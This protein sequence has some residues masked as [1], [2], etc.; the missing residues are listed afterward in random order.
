MNFTWDNVQYNAMDIAS[1]IDLIYTKRAVKIYGIPRGGIYAAQA[2]LSF[3]E[4]EAYLVEK[5]DNDC[6]FID[7][8]IDTGSTR[9][10]FTSKYGHSLSFYALIDKTREHKS[11]KGIWISF[12]WE[13]MCKEKGPI[14]NVRRLIEYIG[15]DPER[16]GLKETPDRVIKSYKTL[17]GGYQQKPSEIIKVFKDDTCDEMVLVK[18]IEFYSTCEHHMLPFYG[19]AHIAY[20]PKGKV[21]GASKLIRLLEIFSRRLQIQERLCQQI[22]EALDEMIEPHGSACI[23]EAQHLCMIARGVKKQHSIMTTSSL[24]GSFNTSHNTRVE[25]LTLIKKGD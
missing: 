5:P 11:L 21:I 8:I 13:R 16:E 20:I 14:D 12:P 6:I 18:D 19:K 3:T 1:K 4:G 23:L 9:D 10:K 15:D 17:F 7:D 22:T 24:T 2:V 25:L